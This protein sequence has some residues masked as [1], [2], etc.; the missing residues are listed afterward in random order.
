[1]MRRPMLVAVP[2]LASTLVLAACGDDNSKQG[3]TR[4]AAGEVLEGTIS[5]AMLPLDETRSQAPLAPPELEKPAVDGARAKAGADAA[6][7]KPAEGAEDTAAPASTN[8]PV[9]PARPAATEKAADPI[10]A[11]VEAGSRN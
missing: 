2:L 9:I 8:A 6:A 10:G 11:A 5:D 7:V 4:A 1:M 3:K